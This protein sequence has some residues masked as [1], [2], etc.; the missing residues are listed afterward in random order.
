MNS[1]STSADEPSVFLIQINQLAGI[2]EGA[3][4][5]GES[6]GLVEGEGAGEFL[7]HG[8]TL[9]CEPKGLGHLGG[10]IVGG[11]LDPPGEGLG[12]V[13]GE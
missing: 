11:I 4:E 3:A 7:G 9:V 1:G 2:E 5:G 10:G 12:H 13:E 6:G 8:V